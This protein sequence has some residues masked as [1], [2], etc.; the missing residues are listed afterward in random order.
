MIE[1]AGTWDYGWAAPKTE[2][3]QWWAVMRSYEIPM[4]HMTPASG[5]KHRMLTEHDSFE[6]M[7]KSTELTPVFVDEDAD[8]ELEDFDHPDNA[9]YVFGK[10]NYSPARTHGKGYMSV[11]IDCPK[12]GMF[13]PHQAL[14]LVM[15]ERGRP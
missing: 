14:A 11:R 13:W 10:A 12:V 7:L 2:F 3:D 8:V 5:M 1:V 6:D 4:L 15:R 9:L